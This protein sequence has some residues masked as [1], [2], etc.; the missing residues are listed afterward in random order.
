MTQSLTSF[1]AGMRGRSPFRLAAKRVALFAL[2]ALLMACDPLA[3]FEPVIINEAQVFAIQAREVSSTTTGTEKY[4]WTNTETQAAVY[5]QTATRGGGSASIRIT[6]AAGTLVY[7]SALLP[8]QMQ[9]TVKGVPGTWQIVVTMTGY[10]GTL[11]FQ[12]LPGAP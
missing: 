9:T 3:A 7:S 10:T 4:D 6:D 8:D 5:H 11:G 2:S 12:V 1:V